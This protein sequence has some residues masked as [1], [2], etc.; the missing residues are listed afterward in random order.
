MINLPSYTI[1][2]R[3]NRIMENNIG[4]L[5]EI[6]KEYKVIISDNKKFDTL[7]SKDV[8]YWRYR[9]DLNWRMRVL[10]TLALPLGHGTI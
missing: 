7:L 9:P 3:M 2:Y 10:Q 8:E 1:T 4:Y 5:V 6:I